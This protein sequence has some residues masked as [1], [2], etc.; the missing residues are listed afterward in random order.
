MDLMRLKPISSAVKNGVSRITVQMNFPW[1]LA[2][3]VSTAL[4]LALA[5]FFS[6]KLY[7]RLTRAI[8]VCVILTGFLLLVFGL[9]NGFHRS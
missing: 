4:W 1:V 3:V 7:P 9:I 5:G 8:Q 2:V 6:S